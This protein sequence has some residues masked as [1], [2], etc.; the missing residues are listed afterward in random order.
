M[1]AEI[2]PVFIGD[3][4][5]GG[6]YHVDKCRTRQQNRPIARTVRCSLRIDRKLRRDKL[7]S[8]EGNSSEGASPISSLSLRSE[9]YIGHH[10]RCHKR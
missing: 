5:T 9:Q 6:E 3:Y 7:L 8:G 4:F 10:R 2:L 1:S